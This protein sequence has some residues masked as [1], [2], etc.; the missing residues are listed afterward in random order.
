MLTLQVTFFLCQTRKMR[1]RV[2]VKGTKKID[3][4][5]T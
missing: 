2:K 4:Q 5:L 1:E 3:K